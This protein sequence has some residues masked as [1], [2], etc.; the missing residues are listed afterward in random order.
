MFTLDS[1]IKGMDEFMKTHT[2]ILVR[3]NRSLGGFSSTNSLSTDA[4]SA[5]ESIPETNNVQI[6]N[7]SEEEVKISYE[8]IGKEKIWNTDEYLSK[9]GVC[10]KVEQ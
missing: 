4:L 9:Y 10:R 2:I 7:E 1:E 8:W 6:S 5:I 3:D